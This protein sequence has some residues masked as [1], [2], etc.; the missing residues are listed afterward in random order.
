MS[1][2]SLQKS[3]FNDITFERL[4]AMEGV[5]GAILT[6]SGRKIQSQTSLPDAQAAELAHLAR[7]LCRGYR[8]VRRVPTKILM[9]YEKSAILVVSRDDTQL[10]LL[11]ESSVD[12]DTIGSAALAFLTKRTQR[13]LRLPSPKRPAA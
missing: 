13:P 6:E 8:K 1:S 2:S 10:V 9:A 7:G 4:R 5:S 11:L 3:R 12:I